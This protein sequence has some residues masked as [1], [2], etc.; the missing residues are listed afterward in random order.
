MEEG[1]IENW[2]PLETLIIGSIGAVSIVRFKLASESQPP[3]FIN[4][5]VYVPLVVSVSPFQM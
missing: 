3:L 5:A 2:L 1:N 4:S